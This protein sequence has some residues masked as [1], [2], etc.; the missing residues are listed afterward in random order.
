MKILYIDHYAG[1]DKYGMEFRPFYMA[2]EWVKMGHEV[3]VLG[4]DFSHLRKKN[5]VITKD[6]DEE[7]DEGVRFVWF[8]SNTYKSNGVKRFY[9]M[10]NFSHKLKKYA[11]RLAADRY[12]AVIASST[13][14]MDNYGARKIADLS[15]AKQI[16]EIHDLWPLSLMVMGN[17]G[18]KNP[19]I[20]YIQKAE[21]F[22]FKNADKIVSILP[23][24]N[25]HMK[26]RGFSD[27]KFVCVPN[28]IVTD[29]K[30]TNLSKDSE[31]YKVLSKLKSQ[32]KFILM[33]AGGH[34]RSNALDSFIL[35]ADDMPENI[36]IVMVGDGVEKQRLVELAGERK[37]ITFLP[38]VKKTD[39]QSLL[40]FADCL[41]IGAKSSP[42]YSYGVGMNKIYDYMLSARPIIYAIDSANKPVEEA[43]CG[44]T[45]KPEDKS[46]IVRAAK[47]ILSWSDEQKNEAGERAKSFVL[48]HHDY[49]VLAQRFLDELSK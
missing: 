20:M 38:S 19:L 15:G 4:A 41:Y 11:K 18:P 40:S 46:E 29:E 13:F 45:V 33:Y 36:H 7:Y 27:E 14:P 8:R 47:E 43:D 21:D 12:D 25:L 17:V 42:L 16:Y 30:R 26:E 5:P 35:S 1:S 3:T 23:F 22:A 10:I 39:M 6:F 31:H 34:A 2:R 28:G 24:A 32:G 37:N 44:I 48:N 49:K 9:S